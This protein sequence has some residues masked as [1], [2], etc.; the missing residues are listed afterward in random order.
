MRFVWVRLMALVGLSLI[1][2]AQFPSPLSAVEA[3][4]LSFS[5]GRRAPSRSIED[6]ESVARAKAKGAR[7]ADQEANRALQGVSATTSP[8]VESSFDAIPMLTLATPADPTGA[9]GN[10]HILTAVNVHYAMF[11]RDGSEEIAP[12]TLKS[13]FAGQFPRRTRVFDPKVVYDHFADRYILAFLAFKWSTRQSWLLM[14]SIPDATALAPET[15]CAR[16]LKGDQVAGNGAQLADFPGLGFDDSRVYVT[17]NQ[18]RFTDNPSFQYAQVWAFDKASLYNCVTEPTFKVF[19]RNQTKNPNGTPAFTI[20][21]AVTQAPAAGTGPAYL[22]S[23]QWSCGQANCTGQ[24]ITIWQIESQFD[25][26]LRLRK[27][28][29]DVPK[30]SIAPYGGQRGGRGI[31]SLWDTGDLRFLN[32]FYDRSADRLYTAHSIR[33]N[34]SEAGNDYLESGIKVYEIDP[35]PSPSLGSSVVSRASVIVSPETDAAWPV[36]ATDG[37]GNVWVAYSRAAGPD[38]TSQFPSEYLSAWVGLIPSGTTVPETT[39][40]RQGNARY[41]ISPGIERWGDYNGISRDP[42]DD[43]TMWSFNQY[44][45]GFGATRTDSWQQVVHQVRAMTGP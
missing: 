29:I 28:S 21:P 41:E 37:S 13:L 42:M 40:L 12:R 11:G 36:V 20:Q 24:K 5:S 2:I 4:G 30:V 14:V 9:T 1:V 34:V 44:P 16:K 18:F 27:R 35:E 32:A 25:G 38:R 33:K 39:V 15:W 45:E 43:S 26:S 23:F 22:L 10:S 6:P 19:S 31:E 17:T 3:E 8:T 7:R